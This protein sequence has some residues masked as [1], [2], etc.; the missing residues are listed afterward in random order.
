MMSRKGP[1]SAAS[2]VHKTAWHIH[3]KQYVMYQLWHSS[4][5]STC[6]HNYFSRLKW[7][8]GL[9]TEESGDHR[10]GWD[11]RKVIIVL[12]VWILLPRFIKNDTKW[13]L[14]SRFGWNRFNVIQMTQT[15]SDKC[16]VS[17]MFLWAHILGT[18]EHLFGTD[19]INISL[20]IQTFVWN[21]IFFNSQSMS[22]SN[23]SVLLGCSQ[24]RHC[25]VTL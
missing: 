12:Y 6:K 14:T 22:R 7:L 23:W 24:Q 21:C 8:V 16:R 20:I 18:N 3:C 13:G 4:Q 25:W 5:L 11:I 2:L 1:L 9:V 15:W 17:Y 19:L 10:Q